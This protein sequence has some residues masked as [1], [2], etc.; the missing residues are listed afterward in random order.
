M[1]TKN[2]SAKSGLSFELFYKY[3]EMSMG[4]WSLETTLPYKHVHIVEGQI[5][6]ASL[7]SA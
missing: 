7:H 2:A 1:K 5:S 4:K 6:L 3:V